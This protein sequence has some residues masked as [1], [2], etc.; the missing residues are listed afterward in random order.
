MRRS[1]TALQGAAKAARKAH[2][3][4][5]PDV[6]Q[7]IAA[8]NLPD[9]ADAKQLLEDARRAVSLAKKGV[10]IEALARMARLDRE[11]LASIEAYFDLVARLVDESRKA[12]RGVTGS[13]TDDSAE[14]PSGQLERRSA[15]R[16]PQSIN[17]SQRP[18]KGTNDSG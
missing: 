14:A 6:M 10:G 18:L 13:G 16:S 3:L 11:S 17:S 8:L 7:E 2:V 9:D 12:A 15:R 1:G 5:P 4:R